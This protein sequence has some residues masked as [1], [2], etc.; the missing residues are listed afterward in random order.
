MSLIILSPPASEPVSLDEMK[1]HLRV[2]HNDEDALIASLTVAA[3]QTVEARA[4]LALISQHWRLTLDTPPDEIFFLPLSP[5]ASVDE[6]SV[7]NKS[8][9]PEIIDVNLY[10]ASAAT[11]GRVRRAGIWPRSGVRVDGYRIDFTAGWPDASEV[12]AALKQAIKLLAAQFFETREAAGPDRI[13]QIPGTVDALIAPFK[14]VR[15]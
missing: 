3:R 15:L 1:A 14:Q 6:I 5:V 11:I 10:E 2:A 7:I 9:D 8:G 13:Y 12:P 4:G